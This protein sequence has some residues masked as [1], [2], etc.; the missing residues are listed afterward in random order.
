MITRLLDKDKRTRLGVNGVQEILSHP[1][2]AGLDIDK[3]LAKEL[4]PPYIPEKRD[5]LAYFD[6]KLVQQT[7]IAESVVPLKQREIINAGQH[8]FKGF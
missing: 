6:Q 3:L 4:T 1:W 5:E 7:E 2:F 8:N